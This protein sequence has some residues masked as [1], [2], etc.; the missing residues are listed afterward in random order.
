MNLSMADVRKEFLRVKSPSTRNVESINHLH[1]NLPYFREES[2]SEKLQL[3]TLS[4]PVIPCGIIIF[5]C[6]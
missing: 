5:I 2:L 3:L 1:F 6:P 4:S